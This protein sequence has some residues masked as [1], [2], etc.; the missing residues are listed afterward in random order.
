MIRNIVCEGTI[1][2]IIGEPKKVKKLNEVLG[3]INLTE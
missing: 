1:K 3:N 2:E